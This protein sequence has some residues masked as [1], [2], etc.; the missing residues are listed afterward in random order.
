M[1]PG[2]ASHDAICPSLRSDL[3]TT[4]FTHHFLYILEYIQSYSPQESVATKA[5]PKTQL[6]LHANAVSYLDVSQAN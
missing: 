1:A 3:E 4:E 6:H 5:E 2:V